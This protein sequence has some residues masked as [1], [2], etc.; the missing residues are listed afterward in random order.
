MSGAPTPAP[1]PGPAGEVRQ[2]APRRERAKPAPQGGVVIRKSVHRWRAWRDPYHLILTL[3]WP[4]FFALLTAF[5]LA[6]NLLFATAY[7]LTG[8]SVEHA[9]PGSFVDVL[10]FSI[11]TLAT[12]GYGEMFPGTVAG[13][14][15][16]SLEI[17]VGLMSLA[18]VTGLVFAR[19]SKPTARVLFS[20]KVVLRDFDGH[21]VLMLRVANERHNRMVEPT[22]HLGL[23]RLEQT[24]GGEVYYRIHDLALQRQRNQVF[25]LTWTLVHRI[26]ETS[27]LYGW[28]KEAL[29]AAR[30]RITVSIIGHDETIAAA[31]HALHE[32]PATQLFF[33]HRFV[34]IIA[35]AGEETR[36]IDLT[37]FHDI[38]P[39]ASEPAPHDPA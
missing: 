33:D 25:A 32:Y 15:I 5:F 22:A 6:V 23:L 20:D 13:H 9:R 39:S 36:I 31:V 37:R 29:V 27:P 34:D 11:E 14:A 4:R 19:F 2:R 35:D 1:A 38:V 17:L 12:V 26:D 7:W 21:R 3:S 10:F 28:S 24:A 8:G 30:A 18:V 16:S